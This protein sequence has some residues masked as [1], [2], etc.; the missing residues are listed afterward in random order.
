MQKNT[1]ENDIQTQSKNVEIEHAS[2]LQSY[3]VNNISTCLH[4][5][6]FNKLIFFFD[7]F[8][9]F[10]S[11]LLPCTTLH[12]W[13]LLRFSSLAASAGALEILAAQG[14]LTFTKGAL[15]GLLKDM[16]NH[17]WEIVGT[18][19]DDQRSVPLSGATTAATAAVEGEEEEEEEGRGGGGGGSLSMK[20]KV[21]IIMG[22]EGHGMRKMVKRNCTTL[23][24]IPAA[25]GSSSCNSLNVSVT[26]ALMLQHY[27]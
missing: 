4:F 25:I 24:S 17:D 11:L 5:D 2:I 20:N 14:R 22:S 16:A 21:A 1:N 23:I 27:L 18:V 9:V 6:L 19:V 7:F 13:M 15:P 10:F 12:L 26:S 3:T 8:F